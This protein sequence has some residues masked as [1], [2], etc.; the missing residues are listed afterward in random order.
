MKWF[1]WPWRKAKPLPPWLP[2]SSRYAFA[3][4]KEQEEA[5]SRYARNVLETGDGLTRK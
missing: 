1:R 2:T 5:M 4:L 3:L